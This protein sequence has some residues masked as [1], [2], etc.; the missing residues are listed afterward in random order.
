MRD[1]H[2]DLERGLELEEKVA[3]RSFH[4]YD[5]PGH[6]GT[7][8]TVTET[9]DVTCTCVDFQRAVYTKDER[10]QLKDT[11]R[12]KFWLKPYGHKAY[13]GCG[14]VDFLAERGLLD[15]QDVPR[16]EYGRGTLTKRI[17]DLEASISNIE[18]TIPSNIAR[19]VEDIAAQVDSIAKPHKHPMAGVWTGTA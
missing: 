16:A 18:A 15:P 19:R 9:G 5:I 13:H 4:V 6:Y 11:S 12:A 10:Y 1:P 17:E 3:S 2:K 7:V 8:V 14:H